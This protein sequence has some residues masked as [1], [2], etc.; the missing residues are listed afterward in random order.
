MGHFQLSSTKRFEVP[1]IRTKSKPEGF[2]VPRALVFLAHR[3]SVDSTFVAAVGLILIIAGAI[4]YAFTFGG[5]SVYDRIA[6]L[7]AR[8]QALEGKP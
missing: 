5:P 2:A 3:G 7:E 4:S 8:V 6:E 1:H